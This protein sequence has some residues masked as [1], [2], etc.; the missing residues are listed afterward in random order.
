MHPLNPTP[1]SQLPQVFY[2]SPCHRAHLLTYPL[3]Y[4]VGAPL[5]G[6]L[7]QPL[8][9]L[10]PCPLNLSPLA[11]YVRVPCHLAHVSPELVSPRQRANETLA[12]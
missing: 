6:V 11:N 4:L 3:N 1:L 9:T 10:S 5:R 2:L 12:P 8:V 7:T